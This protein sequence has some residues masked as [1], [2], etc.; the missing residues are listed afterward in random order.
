MFHSICIIYVQEGHV[1]V[2]LRKNG[3]EKDEK[4]YISYALTILFKSFREEEIIGGVSNEYYICI[5]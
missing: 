5:W 3:Y 1:V 2:N 4:E